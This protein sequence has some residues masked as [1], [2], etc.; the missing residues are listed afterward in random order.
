MALAESP[1]MHLIAKLDD[2]GA[3]QTSVPSAITGTPP[4]S[5]PN[6]SCASEPPPLLSLNT[7]R[8]TPGLS[9]P[10]RCPPL[11]SEF[12]YFLDENRQIP[13]PCIGCRLITTSCSASCSPVL[14]RMPCRL[15]SLLGEY[16]ACAPH[17]IDPAEEAAHAAKITD[18]FSALWSNPLSLAQQSTEAMATGDLSESDLSEPDLPASQLESLQQVMKMGSRAGGLWM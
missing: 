14:E 3:V 8:A 17:L 16:L 9:S 12:G 18:D 15:E 13:H 5:P 2:A 1:H 6:Q 7:A 4:S 10:D 11:A